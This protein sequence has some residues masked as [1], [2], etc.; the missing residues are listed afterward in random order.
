MGQ[1]E[2]GNA[3]LRRLV[4]ACARIVQEQQECVVSAALCS[5]TI[6]CGEE[7]I[8]FRLLQIGNLCSCSFLEWDGANLSAPLNV[9]G[10]VLSDEVCERMKRGESLI[11]RR[12]AA[13]A[14]LFQIAKKAP[15][16]F[17]RHIH[18]SKLVDLFAEVLT[19]E[20]DQQAEHVAITPL[21][22]T[23]QVAFTHEMLK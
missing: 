5:A 15:H 21:R 12:H 9:F 13:A 8:H 18:H 11:S 17:C 6:G 14:C 3:K 10:A 7:R 16:K 1:V 4:G 19:D 2:V 23:S 20:W 22:I